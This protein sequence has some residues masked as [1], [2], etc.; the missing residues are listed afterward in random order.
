V[1]DGA[2]ADF[3]GVLAFARQAI[4]QPI[5]LARGVP[6]DLAKT[7]C[8]KPPRGSRSQ[9]SIGALAIDDDGALGIVAESPVGRLGGELFEGQVD[10][11][12]EVLG[13][14]FLTRQHFDDGGALG[15]EL[16]EASAL[17]VV[18]HAN[19]GARRVPSGW[20]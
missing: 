7:Q 11:A 9:V 14:E 1:E 17:D 18:W 2:N 20:F 12:R 3:I 19:S 6:V 15:L 13:V 10:G 16:L 4:A 5:D 8:F